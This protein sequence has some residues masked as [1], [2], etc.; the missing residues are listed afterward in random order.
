MCISEH[1]TDPT[2]RH[3]WA[4]IC[5]PCGPGMGFT[6]CPSFFGNDGTCM[7][8][9]RGAK[10]A[11]RGPFV[12]YCEPCPVCD[13]RGAYD[14][15]AVRVVVGVRRGVRAGAGPGRGDPGVDF[16]CCVM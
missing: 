5:Q 7:Y 13:L 8:A 6:T 11:P 14:R 2:C 12:V 15:N 3:T 10:P 9:R 1:Y 4:R 16:T